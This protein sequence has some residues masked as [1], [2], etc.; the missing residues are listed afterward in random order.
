MKYDD[1]WNDIG[2][3][4]G[5][6]A[7]AYEQVYRNLLALKGQTFDAIYTNIRKEA[8]EILRFGGKSQCRH[9]NGSEKP[10]L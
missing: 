8:N 2:S 5:E 6:M 10:K 3:S 4:N 7:A 1:I 9:L